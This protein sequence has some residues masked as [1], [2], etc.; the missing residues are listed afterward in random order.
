M[1]RYFKANLL[2]FLIL[3]LPTLAC[4]T[5]PAVP[6]DQELVAIVSGIPT[7]VTVIDDGI[8]NVNGRTVDTRI[9]F[10]ANLKILDVI[11]GEF[12]QNYLE[13]VVKAHNADIA[14][15]T[16]FAVLLIRDGDTFRK[17][18]AP[19]SRLACWS[20][21]S[22]VPHEITRRIRYEFADAESKNKC[23]VF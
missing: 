9:D 19:A 23:I 22:A 14:K 20:P 6:I 15:A 3:P 11:H 13:V 17:V 12:E 16:V 8:P 7:K 4:A 18:P 2:L 5:T 1:P 21:D 10:L